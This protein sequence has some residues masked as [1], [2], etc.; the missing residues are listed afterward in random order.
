MLLAAQSAV[1]ITRRRRSLRMTVRSGIERHTRQWF[2]EVGEGPPDR[3]VL[4]RPTPP[5]LTESH[6]QRTIATSVVEELG[7]ARH[8]W[9]WFRH[10]R[11]C[12]R[13]AVIW[14]TR[15][16]QLR[17]RK[18]RPWRARSKLIV[19][20]SQMSRRMREEATHGDL[21]VIGIETL[22]SWVGGGTQGVG[23][24]QDV[25]RPLG[26]LFTGGHRANTATLAH[27][28]RPL[29]T[30]VV[31]VQ[32]GTTRPPPMF[33]RFATG[34]TRPGCHIASVGPTQVRSGSHWSLHPFPHDRSVS[35][36]LP[37]AARSRALP[38]WCQ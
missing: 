18:T 21:S 15:T 26:G 4:R 11:R 9:R 38:I 23:D 14:R 22:G 10:V 34:E 8:K 28:V 27:P 29:A 2:V 33:D 7:Q 24:P 30:R 36:S 35:R 3:W 12:S 37:W 32:P 5:R 13:R 16:D 6:E 19:A 31:A 1:G 25:P 17:A 20:E